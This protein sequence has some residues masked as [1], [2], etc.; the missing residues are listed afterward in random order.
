MAKLDLCAN[1]SCVIFKFTK[2]RAEQIFGLKTQ[3]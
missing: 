2:L 3:S 1:I